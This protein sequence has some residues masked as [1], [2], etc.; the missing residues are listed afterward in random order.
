MIAKIIIIFHRTCRL[1]IICCDGHATKGRV[2]Q[3]AG[4]RGRDWTYDIL[5]V[6]QTLYHWAT[7]LLERVMGFEPTTFSL[8]TRHS[9][10][11]LHPQ[12]LKSFHPMLYGIPTGVYLTQQSVFHTQLFKGIWLLKVGTLALYASCQI[13]SGLTLTLIVVGYLPFSLCFP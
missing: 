6:N 4:G 7:F 5:G 3:K 9:T 1:L 2:R 11:E 13:G 8:A 12:V 10:T